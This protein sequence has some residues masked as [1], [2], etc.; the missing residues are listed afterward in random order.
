MDEPSLICEAVQASSEAVPNAVCRQCG[1]VFHSRKI[2]NSG[3]L[4]KW[5]DHCALNPRRPTSEAKLA[6]RESMLKDCKGCGTAF[7]TKD[8]RQ[9]Y[10]TTEC[11]IT[12][13]STTY[14]Q[15]AR[16]VAKEQRKANIPIEGPPNAI[17]KYCGNA[18]YSKPFLGTA[19]TRKMCRDCVDYAANGKRTAGWNDPKP[20]RNC[21]TDFVPAGRRKVYCSAECSKLYVN[22][23][24][25]KLAKARRR[26]ATNNGEL[27]DWLA[28][29]KRDRWICHMCNRRT[30][31]SLRGTQEDLAPE[32]DHIVP[33]AV[34]GS[35]TYDNCACSCHTCNIRKR[36]KVQGQLSL[37]GNSM[38]P[39]TD[40][41]SS[42]H[43]MYQ[44]M[45]D[46][47]DVAVMAAIEELNAKGEPVLVRS[48][49]AISGISIHAIKHA[50]N[51]QH[52]GRPQ[53]PWADLVLS[54][55]KNPKLI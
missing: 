3:K 24:Y 55:V 10:C 6:S 9:V 47:R 28:V 41:L 4:R 44:S 36:D 49:V 31:K 54:A 50:L 39:V 19:K 35:H 48:I 45:R 43:R 30:K 42:R 22:R 16:E 27:V 38:V 14:R 51:W 46:K 26:G 15:T 17:C 13:L 33:I 7:A 32:L 21:Q 2:G 12:F 18:F 37:F 34:G 8:W 5:C 53:P 11:R 40:G 29:M 1:E 52:R 20:C 25:R 23:T